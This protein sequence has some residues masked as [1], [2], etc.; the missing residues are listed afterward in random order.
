MIRDIILLVQEKL[1]PLAFLLWKNF[2]EKIITTV[3]KDD[4]KE[5]QSATQIVSKT[6]VT[7]PTIYFYN[8][9][10]GFT[11]IVPDAVNQIIGLVYIKIGLKEYT[12]PIILDKLLQ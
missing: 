9:T 3:K 5:Y 12:A 8:M 6:T 2:I 10:N 4:I 7:A 11:D 1:Y